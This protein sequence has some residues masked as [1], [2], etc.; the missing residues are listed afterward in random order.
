MA[1]FEISKHC[2]KRMQQRGRRHDEVSFVLD[3][4]S[5]VKEGYILTEKNVA[6]IESE[7]KQM[8][9]LANRLKNVFVPC[10]ENLAKTVFRASKDQQR[11]ML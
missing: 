8:I 4:G 6:E 1:H 5:E 11:R 7:A 10:A 2:L 3:H 9:E